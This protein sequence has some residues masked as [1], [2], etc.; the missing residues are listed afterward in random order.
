[1]AVSIFVFLTGSTFTFDME[2]LKKWEHLIHGPEFEIDWELKNEDWGKQFCDNW[3]PNDTSRNHRHFL[4]PGGPM[5]GAYPFFLDLKAG[6]YYF[7]IRCVKDQRRSY[8]LV[9]L[10]GWNLLAVW[11]QSEMLF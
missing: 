1:M 9:A 2:G 5:Y 4:E 8:I 11:R 7:A 3:S 10:K 6:E